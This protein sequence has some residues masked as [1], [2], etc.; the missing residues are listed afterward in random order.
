MLNEVEQNPLTESDSFVSRKLRLLF[1]Y[2]ENRL[3]Q[4]FNYLRGE[5]KYP[6]PTPQ[7]VWPACSVRLRAG[8][9]LSE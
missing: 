7:P 5:V 4:S 1:F 9:P 3:K 2:L 8:R 6:H